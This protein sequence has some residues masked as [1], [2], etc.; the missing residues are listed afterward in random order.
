MAFVHRCF[1][2]ISVVWFKITWGTVH[3]TLEKLKNAASFLRS[4]LPATL[5]YFENGAFW[6]HSSNH[7]NLKTPALRF[8]VD[9]KHFLKGALQERWCHDNH[10]ISLREISS[11]LNPKWPVIA[12]FSNFSGVVRTENSRCV[13]RVKTPFSNFPGIEWTEPWSIFSDLFATR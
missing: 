1:K 7:R 10:V 4:G 5:I 11:K 9:G 12:A 8:S 6:K 2:L 13:F 3:A